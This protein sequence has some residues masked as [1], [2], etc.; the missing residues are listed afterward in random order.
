[1]ATIEHGTETEQ[2]AEVFQWRFEQLQRAGYPASEALLLAAVRDV[3]LRLAARLLDQGCP[4][5][6]AARILA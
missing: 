5:A 1:M 3:D 6:T 2:D 4:P